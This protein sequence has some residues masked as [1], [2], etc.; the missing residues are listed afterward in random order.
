MGKVM[1]L[2]LRLKADGLL[3]DRVPVEWNFDN[4]RVIRW[5]LLSGL[6]SPK[7]DLALWKAYKAQ[8][9]DEINHPRRRTNRPL[10]DFLADGFIHLA[11]SP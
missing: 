9:F 5:E 11:P 2:V 3:D 6:R 8:R 10:R 1:S 4:G 7:E